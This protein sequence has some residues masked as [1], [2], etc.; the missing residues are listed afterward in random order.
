MIFPSLLVP[1]SAGWLERSQS[2]TYATSTTCNCQ[3]NRPFVRVAR[4]QETIELSCL[5]VFGRFWPSSTT[6]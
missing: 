3:Y 5:H 6:I 1:L 4:A 2:C